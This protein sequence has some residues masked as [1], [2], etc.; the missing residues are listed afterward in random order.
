MCI[1]VSFGFFSPF[2]VYLFF[3]FQNCGLINRRR[4]RRSSSSGVTASSWFVVARCC[5]SSDAAPAPTAAAT[6]LIHLFGGVS[7][8]LPLLQFVGISRDVYIFMHAHTS[9]SGK[10]KKWRK[11]R[12]EIVFVAIQC[13]R[14]RKAPKSFLKSLEEERVFASNATGHTGAFKWETLMKRVGNLA[15]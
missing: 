14:Q 7:R 15:T 4:R 11:L 2:F 1:C 13:D 6:S 3:T 12:C 5:G 10:N 9:R 8:S